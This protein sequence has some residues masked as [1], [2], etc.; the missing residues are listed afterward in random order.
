MTVIDTYYGHSPS[1]WENLKSRMALRFSMRGCKLDPNNPQYWKAVPTE[2]V[3][4][5]SYW[6]LPI[7]LQHWIGKPSG[8]SS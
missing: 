5:L 8:I 3:D 1:S 7:R 4:D 6:S 2:L